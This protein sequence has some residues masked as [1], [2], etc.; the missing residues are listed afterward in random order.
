LCPG[1]ADWRLIG[2]VNGWII[3]RYNVAPFICTLGTM[4]VLR[5]AA[6]LTSDGQTFPG[7]PAIRSWAIPALMR[8]APVR[9]LA[10]RGPSG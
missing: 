8:L 6:M 10:F 2:A 7:F 3:T 4:Y 1:A 5:G 9:C